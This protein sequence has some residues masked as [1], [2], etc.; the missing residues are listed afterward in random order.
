MK[1][2]NEIITKIVEESGLV[3]FGIRA[4]EKDV[5]V[6]DDLENS[7]QSYEDCEPEEL[8]GTCAVRIDYDGWDVTNIEESLKGLNKYLDGG[9]RKAILVGGS[10][11]YEGTDANETV[12]SGAVVLHIF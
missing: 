2:L 1:N 9:R 3:A 10:S 5:Q 4:E 6:G 11:S 8:A 7:Y 12:I